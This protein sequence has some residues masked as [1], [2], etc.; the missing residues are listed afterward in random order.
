MAHPLRPRRLLETALYCD[1]LAAWKEQLREWQIAI[2]SRV[3]WERG[4]VSLYVR[5]PDGRSVV[6]AT[7]GTWPTY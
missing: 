2:E 7:E 6:L 1:D 5:D 3:S 4:G